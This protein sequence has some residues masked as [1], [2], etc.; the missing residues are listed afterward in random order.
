MFVCVFV[1]VCGFNLSTST[2]TSRLHLL[3]N[4]TQAFSVDATKAWSDA[5]R[6]ASGFIFQV[7]AQRLVRLTSSPECSEPDCTIT[8]YHICACVQVYRHTVYMCNVHVH[9]ICVFAITN[10]F[11]C[12]CV[13]QHLCMFVFMCLLTC[14]Y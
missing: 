13:C 1:C 8:G 2:I 3:P 5:S 4:T 14:D 6:P 11:L 12:M 7:H 10:Y 9:C